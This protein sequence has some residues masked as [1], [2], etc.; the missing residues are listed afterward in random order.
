MELDRIDHRILSVLQENADLPNTAL[1]QQ[2]GL[3]PSACLR[4]V[5][6]LK[7]NGVIRRIVAVVDPAH[8]DR[9]LSAVVTVNLDR[10]GP[11]FRRDFVARVKREASVSQCYMVAGEVSC[12]LVVQVADMEEYTALTDRLFHADDNV[13][14]FT[15]YLVMSTTKQ[16]ISAAIN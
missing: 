2:V 14:A 11:E 5:A 15:S 13:K 1:A 7:Q 16:E 8:L 12:V 6:R 4:R 10:H 3:S 9:R